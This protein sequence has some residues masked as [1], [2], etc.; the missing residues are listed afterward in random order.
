MWKSALS[1]LILVPWLGGTPSAAGLPDTLAKV[2]RSVVAV[3]VVALPARDNPRLLGSGF[4][5]SNG[6]HAVT[7]LS[8]IG[9]RGSGSKEEVGIM[10]PVA[11]SRVSFRPAAVVLRDKE[12]DLCILRFS[13]TPL[14]AL[15]LGR[16]EDVREGEL[17][18]FTGYPNGGTVGLHPV[19]HRALVA[20][21][22]PNVLPVASGGKLGRDLLKKL[23]R[24]FDVFQLDA[25][26]F[27]GDSGSP[28]YEI[29]TG[30]VVGVVNSV[31]VKQ[32]KEMA[33]SGASGISYA[34]PV[35]HVRS[36]LGRAGL[37]Y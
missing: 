19:T 21:I 29:D 2:K 24:P 22:S 23:D 33:G 18:A 20:A 35:S 5:V 28:L 12:H 6:N 1:I 10:I 17:H 27:P 3:G 14:P 4:T 31:F 32:T 16:Q 7:T 13:G 34:I 30:R 9:D 8:S 26:A 25:T 15:R 36:L 11:G 37:G